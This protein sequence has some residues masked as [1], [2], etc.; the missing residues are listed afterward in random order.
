MIKMDTERFSLKWNDF[1][2][3][4]SNSF[5]KLRQ[6]TRLYDVT[7]VSNDHQ[8][9]SAHKLVLSACSEV[10]SNIF[11]NNNGPN[12]MLY[13]DSVDAKEISF[14]L[15]YIY[16]GEVSIH[17]EYL[18]RFIE[19][20][21]K[22]QL[23]GLLMDDNGEEIHEAHYETKDNEY[24]YNEKILE[25]TKKK[26]NH[27]ERSIRPINHPNFEANNAEI[28]EKFEELID[29]EDGGPFRCTVCEKKIKERRDM[30]RHLETH[31]SGL[32]YNCSTCSKNFRSSNALRQ[33]NMKNH[34]FIKSHF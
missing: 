25:D 21:A 14:M 26:T 7:L 2:S 32:S 6:E 28:D 12:M 1:A 19:I 18:D 10:F 15:D 22:F 5:S 11:N 23:H 31:L 3:N 8:Q 34:G 33:H 20:A 4:V 29:K 9:V 17:Q 13:L 24:I 30:K 16:Q 27:Q